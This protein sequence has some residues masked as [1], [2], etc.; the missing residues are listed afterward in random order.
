MRIKEKGYLLK[1]YDEITNTIIIAKNIKEAEDKLIKS[2]IGF[3]KILYNNNI[4]EIKKSLK[5]KELWFLEIQ[6]I[7]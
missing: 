6:K 4:K 1:Y 5:K 2:E 7:I 3:D